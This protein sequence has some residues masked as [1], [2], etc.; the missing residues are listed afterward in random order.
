[1]SKDK[2]QKCFFIIS[3]VIII[4]IGYRQWSQWK[5]DYN[6]QYAQ[7]L[8]EITAVDNKESIIS[9]DMSG[10]KRHPSSYIYIDAENLNEDEALQMLSDIATNYDLLI[11]DLN[12]YELYFGAYDM[13]IH[14]DVVDDSGEEIFKLKANND[15]GYIT[16]EEDIPTW[17]WDIF[18]KKDGEYVRTYIY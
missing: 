9:I 2:K 7:F 13:T 17:S 4:L 15:K 14:L 3:V 16:N 5:N 11:P 8:S 18:Y 12:T 1:M 10:S 6:I